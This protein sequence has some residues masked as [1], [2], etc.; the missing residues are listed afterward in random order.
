MNE[1]ADTP[2]QQE[3]ATPTTGLSEEGKASIEAGIAD[4][5]TEPKE[6]NYLEE[7][8]NPETKELD[9]DRLKEGYEIK[10]KREKDLESQ[11]FGMRQIIGRGR[12]PPKT[13]DEYKDEVDAK[14]NPL[15]ENEQAREALDPVMKNLN[16][17]SW[18][19]GLSVAQ[20][21]VL[22]NMIMDMMAERGIVD[23]RSPEDFAAAQEQWKND[24]LNFLKESYGE[25]TGEVMNKNFKFWKEWEVLDPEERDALWNA[26]D[27]K[28]LQ[29]GAF[30]IKIM[31]KIRKA[32]NFDGEYGDIPMNTKSQAISK[33]DA[34]ASYINEK[35]P[36]KRRAMLEREFGVKF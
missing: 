16:K 22:K 4:T 17:F 6:V 19:H 31:D 32:G 3:E 13:I 18:D 7:Y 21:K 36:E 14:Y 33:S 34:D 8:I 28:P 20:N 10:A 1:V 12:N 11:I 30:L 26:M 9:I 24:Q 15:F 5:P 27:G 35:D 25:K 23:T 29:G 2:I